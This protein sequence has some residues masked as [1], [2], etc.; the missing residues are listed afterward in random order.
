MKEIITAHGAPPAIGPYSH[1][2]RTGGLLFT[3]G[4]I[5]LSPVTGHLVEGGIEA[6]AE[7]V[8]QNLAAVLSAA[9]LDFSS[10]VKATVFLADLA[11]FSAVNAIYAKHF[12]NNP[13]ARS[14]VQVAAL[15]AG[16]GIEIELIAQHEL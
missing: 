2:V 9:G 6:Q 4:Q 7:Q 14:C 11:D 3:S 12:P 16:A 1:A 5:P 8:F 10:V 15:P 13:P